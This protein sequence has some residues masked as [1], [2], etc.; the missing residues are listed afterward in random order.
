MN[1]AV[2][3]G[4]AAVGYNDVHIDDCWMAKRRD[5]NGTCS[6]LFLSTTPNAGE[7]IANQTRF[8][9]GIVNL[10]KYVYLSFNGLFEHKIRLHAVET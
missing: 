8:P 4:Y 1:S 6:D 9:S 5:A 2:T 7:L 10:T 3:D